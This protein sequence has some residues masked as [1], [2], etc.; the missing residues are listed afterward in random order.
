MNLLLAC[1]V[2]FGDPS[3]RQVQGQ[4]AGILTLLMITGGV[5][6]GLAILFTRFIVRARRAQPIQ[7]VG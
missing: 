5:L 7:P 3:S 2:C 4:N 1:A 6:L